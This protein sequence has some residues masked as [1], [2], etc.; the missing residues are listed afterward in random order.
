MSWTII[1]LLVWSLMGQGSMAETSVECPHFD[2][3]HTDRWC[4]WLEGELFALHL[5][6]HFSLPGALMYNLPTY[7]EFCSPE[8]FWREIKSAMLLAL[9][10]SKLMNGCIA[11]RNVVIFAW[12]CRCVVLFSAFL[13]YHSSLLEEDLLYCLRGRS[14][15][16]H[17]WAS[18]HHKKGMRWYWW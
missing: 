5:S 12:F 14:K 1:L 15:H 13:C 17:P 3:I 2:W 11:L 16:L 6:L 8:L 10:S 9:T 4:R 7:L 18:S